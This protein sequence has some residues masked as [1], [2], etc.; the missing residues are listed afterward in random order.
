M[1][2]PVTV[3]TTLKVPFALLATAPLIEPPFALTSALLVSPPAIVPVVINEPPDMT[4]PLL[5]APPLVAVPAV[6]VSKPE[7]V[8]PALL[9]NAPPF[10]TVPVQVL[11]LVMVPAFETM[12]PAQIP[13][14]VMRLVLA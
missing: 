13:L 9:L 4:A 6:L 1:E 10:D 8:A 3:P 12:L 7:T 2:L 14:L 5:I 11:L